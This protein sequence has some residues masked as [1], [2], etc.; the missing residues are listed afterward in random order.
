VARP[1]LDPIDRLLLAALQRDADRPLRDLGAEVGLSESAVHRRVARLRRSG[2][3]ARVVAL[4]DQ[5]RLTPVLT[6]IVL[7]ALER[8]AADVH[9]AFRERMRAEDRVQQC[10]S[11]VGQ[12]DY[13]VVLVTGG[14]TESRALSQELFAALPHVRRYETLPVAEPVKIGL[15]VPLL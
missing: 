11:I 4:L 1:R 6:S 2:V 10:Y 15:Q 9:A 3:L 12:W 5:R 13:A 7:V 8:D 14:L